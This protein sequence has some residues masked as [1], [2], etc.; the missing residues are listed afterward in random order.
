MGSQLSCL[1]QA[2]LNTFPLLLLPTSQSQQCWWVPNPPLCSALPAVPGASHKVEV[3]EFPNMART[4]PAAG[5][6]SR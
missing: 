5:C 1:G 3:T 6:Q 2:A 4:G